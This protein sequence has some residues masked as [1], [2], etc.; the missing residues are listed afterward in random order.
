MNYLMRLGLGMMV[1]VSVMAT[2]SYAEE[3]RKE[4]AQHH[5]EHREE[6]KERQQALKEKWQGIKEEG[7][8]AREEE[9]ALR[10]QM[11]QAVESG[12]MEKAKSLRE[13]LHAM[14][15]KNMMHMKEKHA[16]INNERE[17][18]Q[19]KKQQSKEEFM[20]N[21]PQM[22]ERLEKCKQ[23]GNKECG[24]GKNHPHKKDKPTSHE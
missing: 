11:Q 7:Q 13:K 12:D 17:Q 4:P 15:E 24:K 23:E 9:K 22:K 20:K 21:H 16:A 10:T 18:I 19:Q 8:A 3:T 2:L 6:I 5:G 1:G 14:H